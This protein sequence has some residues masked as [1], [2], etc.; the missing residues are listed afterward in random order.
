MSTTRRSSRASLSNRFTKFTRGVSIDHERG[1]V[2]MVVS[3]YTKG[4]PGR[5]GGSGVA[6]P[7]L[8][9]N[10]VRQN[11]CTPIVPGLIQHSYYLAGHVDAEIRASIDSWSQEHRRRRRIRDPNLN[12]AWVMLG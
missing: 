6:H 3:D 11:D 10:K 4:N 9:H 7:G 12:N 8:L 1:D 5:L 2:A